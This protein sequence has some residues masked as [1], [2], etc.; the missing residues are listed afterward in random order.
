MEGAQE[1]KQPHDSPVIRGL[2]KGEDGKYAETVVLWAIDKTKSP[3]A[4]DFSGKF[5]G[6]FV[7]GFINQR[8]DAS[9]APFITLSARTIDQG[10]GEPSYKQVATGNAMNQRSDDQEVYFDTILFNTEDGKVVQARVT[11]AMS[12]EMHKAIG[13]A[14]EIVARPAKDAD[15]KKV[16]AARP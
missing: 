16:A 11:K 10:S 2:S 15:E 7:T 4:P 13:F 9:K 1:A 5:N 12:A 3:N 6:Q 14:N 8:K